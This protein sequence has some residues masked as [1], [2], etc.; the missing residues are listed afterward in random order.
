[1]FLSQRVGKV[2]L[3]LLRTLESHIELLPVHLSSDMAWRFDR[4]IVVE[5]K[6]QV[7]TL[8]DGQLHGTTGS[9]WEDALLSF[10]RVT[11]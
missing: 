11:S 3:T 7:L 5:R 8:R 10:T 9:S 6:D 2:G 1:M 4:G